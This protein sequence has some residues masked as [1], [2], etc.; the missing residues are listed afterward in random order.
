MAYLGVPLNLQDPSTNAQA[1]WT[2][3]AVSNVNG[4]NL[5]LQ[6]NGATTP[7]KTIRAYNGALNVINHAYTAAILVLD[8]AGNFTLLGSISGKQFAPSAGTSTVAPLAFTTGVNLTTP[9]PGALEYDGAVFYGTPTANCR[10]VIA[11]EQVAVLSAAYTLT[12]QTAAQKLFNATANG[13]LTL[14]V[15]TYEF[16]CVFSLSAMS[17]TSG[18]FGFALGGTAVF[19]QGWRAEAVKAALA[20]ATAPQVSYNTAA[21]VA[22]TTANTTATGH[23]LIKG[24]IRV[25]TAGTIIPQVSL[26]VAAAAIVGVNSYFK[27]KPRG[28][29]G[30][31]SVGNWS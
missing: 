11:T 30:F 22:L 6:G 7:N 1:S 18:A 25:T 31:A 13:A 20:T 16:E 28:A 29:A 3:G 17:A 24:V 12:S 23:A 2:F 4:A 26:G 9:A 8:D 15:G 5:L 10:G 21:N 19:T 14:P 27:I